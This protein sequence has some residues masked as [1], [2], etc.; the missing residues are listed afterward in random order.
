MVKDTNTQYLYFKVHFVLI[1]A[2][3]L[4]LIGTIFVVAALY[5]VDPNVQIRQY[6]IYKGT[7]VNVTRL[8]Y[9][10]LQ[11]DYSINTWHNMR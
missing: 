3:T 11:R 8:L 6:A 9:E 4:L 10:L 2:F 5:L 1:Y 7:A